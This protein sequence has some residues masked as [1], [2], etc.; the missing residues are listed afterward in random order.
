[1]NRIGFVRNA[2]VQFIISGFTVSRFRI[3]VTLQLIRRFVNR[4]GFVRNAFVQF[5]IFSFTGSSFSGICLFQIRHG[6]FPFLC[7][8]INSIGIGFDLSIES[9]KVSP[10]TIGLDYVVSGLRCIIVNSFRFYSPCYRYITTRGDI[11]SRNASGS[12]LPIDFHIF[13]N[14]IFFGPYDQISILGNMQGRAG[15]L[16]R[17]SLLDLSIGGFTSCSF[18]GIRLFQISHGVFPF[19]CFF[20][21]RIS[22]GFDLC[23]QADKV[24]PYCIVLFDVSSVFSSLV[25]HSVRSHFTCYSHIT[26]SGDITSR[27]ASGSQLPIDFH[28]SD[29]LIFFGPYDQISIGNMQGRAGLLVR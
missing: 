7:F 11:T 20:I 18:S 12:Q 19:L 5:I 9:G 8:F 6:V 23:I 1:M 22:I 25:G 3:Q 21:N 29:D 15:L 28:I 26:S 27:N 14:L 16:V 10:H 4:I 17:H 13:D 24:I 2:F